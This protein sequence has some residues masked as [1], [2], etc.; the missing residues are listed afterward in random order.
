MTQVCQ[1]FQLI[2]IKILHGKEKAALVKI[3]RAARNED[4]FSRNNYMIINPLYIPR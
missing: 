1:D 4:N 3:P 2:F